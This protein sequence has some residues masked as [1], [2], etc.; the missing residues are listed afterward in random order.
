MTQRYYVRS[1]RNP[2]KIQ[3]P[4][5]HEQLRTLAAKGKLKPGHEVSVDREEW[6]ACS[7]VRP[8]LFGKPAG[9]KNPEADRPSDG[10][11]AAG[12]GKR[13][14]GSATAND[15]TVV[16]DYVPSGRCDNPAA[17]AWVAPVG[18]LCVAC[19]MVV[20]G[21][22]GWGVGQLTGIV[23]V[24]LAASDSSIGKLALVM[25]S[26][27]DRSPEQFHA[28]M[29]SLSIGLFAVTGAFV[30]TTVPTQMFETK[31]RNRSRKMALFYG[32]LLW[33]LVLISLIAG[34]SFVRDATG[35][36]V[37]EFWFAVT[38]A[39]LIMLG[40]TLYSAFNLSPYCETCGS[41]VAPAYERSYAA[42]GD[43]IMK[44]AK[45]GD[46][47]RLRKLKDSNV[48]SK[49]FTT[50]TLH[51]CDER[52]CA[53]LEISYSSEEENESIEYEGKEI[54]ILGVHTFAK[55][56]L[57]TRRTRAWKSVLKP[58]EKS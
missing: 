35:W 34:S 18:V 32:G 49:S 54:D 16:E 1:P 57:N 44:L 46:V 11:A 26:Q 25:I 43:K 51:T 30:G 17:M 41:F 3:G 28:S 27:T 55:G 33:G 14:R 47:E 8:P 53:Y 2:E 36:T 12:R 52:C 20:G 37:G 38:L 40:W 9:K 4:F 58:V 24:A 10:P 15:L 21:I 19:G 39:S 42:R 13:S 5:R 48:E 7:Q 31:S 6:I 50:V 45:R 56:F 23:V 29:V 22:V